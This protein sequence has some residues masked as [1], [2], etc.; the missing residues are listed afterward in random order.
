[1]AMLGL[2]LH[3][4]GARAA[5]VS[6]AMGIDLGTDNSVVALARKRGVDIVANEASQRS[7]P[8]LVSFC[9]DRRHIG[10]AA[11]SMRMM[12]LKNTVLEPKRLLGK[13]LTNQALM[14]ELQSE[15]YEVVKGA[16][17][18]IAVKVSLCGKERTFAPVQIIAMLLANLKQI[19]EADH[20]AEVVDVAISVP[21]FFAEHQR[22]AILAA[23]EVAG[24]KCLRL[25]NDNTATALAYGIT[26]TDLPEKT[27]P[28]GRNVAFVDC[29]RDCMQVSIV[30]FKKG[31][32]K[33]LS[34]AYSHRVGG[35]K[36]DALL[37]EHFAQEFTDKYKVDA[38]TQDKAR[39]RLL[40][41]CEK[42]KKTLSACPED[43]ETPI[44]V[45]CMMNDVD[46][47][48]LLTRLKLEELLEKDKIFED[49]DA[50]C[51]RALDLAGLEKG[52]LASVEVVGGTSR[53][54]ALRSTI[55]KF[56]GKECQTTVNAAESVARGAALACAMDSP[57][58]KV[59]EF[60]VAD[61]QLH[62]VDVAYSTQDKK[63]SGTL[64]LKQGAEVPGGSSLKLEVGSPITLKYAY[65]AD[66][67]L[68]AEMPHELG[69]HVLKVK[70][71]KK[72]KQTVIAKV[73]FDNSGCVTSDAVLETQVEE[74]VVPPKAKKEELKKEE[75][76][77]KEATAEEGNAPEKGDGAS[78]DGDAEM[79]EGKGE[80]D[81]NE[82]EG[83]KGKKEDEEKEKG[84]DKAPQVKLVT[85]REKIGS[86]QALMVGFK[87][88][89]VGKLKN[90]EFD[91]A[92]ADRVV[93]E[94]NDARNKLEEYVYNMR[95]A[96]SSKLADFED[97][98]KRAALNKE[99]DATEEWIYGDGESANK[100]VFLKRLEEL[101]A[102]G[103]PISARAREFELLPEAFEHL[104]RTA[105]ALTERSQTKEAKFSHISEDERASVAGECALVAEWI[106]QQKEALGAASKLAMPPM[107]CE[108]V[109]A[110]E[111]ELHAL[112]DRVMSKPKPPPPTPP[113]PA[114][115]EKAPEGAASGDG[116]AEEKD[117]PM[118]NKDEAG[119][120]GAGA[121]DDGETGE[122]APAP[123]DMNLD[124][125]EV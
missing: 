55:G 117:V 46:V 40:V 115:D 2:A 84:E 82:K 63:A 91:M 1:M 88:E 103:E 77:E 36:I 67:S 7:T 102:A 100:G 125:V 45:E 39:L 110:K 13:F 68:D 25:I 101:H 87:A 14:D 61:W 37:F 58:F 75:K 16:G 41:Q 114:K 107:T 22:R 69:S 30:S 26:K 81:G 27:D 43:L 35:R 53:I 118:D 38:R 95:D 49:V 83:Q 112:C 6:V 12:N 15:P 31:E 86:D 18:E 116:A 33:M 123:E 79:E 28:F 9:H 74:V 62:P 92:L 70:P 76:S 52:Q 11:Q 94:T 8:S 66:A 99:L 65:T 78:K 90:E 59:R 60:K 119:G 105:D 97:E 21:A 5:P 32:L 98:D 93:I 19:A 64:S 80:K 42:L 89:E 34:H 71:A 57:A 48:G 4:Q 96:L 17:G 54:P 122:P 106:Q 104:Q 23:A 51:Q 111:A 72:G 29:G 73:G 120:E 56:F 113:A 109:A 124:D 50:T 10:E 121:M 47:S 108:Q 24:L 85:R 3:F 20:G 44:N